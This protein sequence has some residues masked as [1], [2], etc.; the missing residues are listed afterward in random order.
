MAVQGHDKMLH[1]QPALEHVGQLQHQREDRHQHEQ[2]G[3][4][5]AQHRV[6]ERGAILLEP[7]DVAVAARD[8]IVQPAVDERR[9]PGIERI[10]LRMPG[11]AV[12]IEADAVLH[13]LRWRQS[14][15]LRLLQL[16]DA[17]G[18]GVADRLLA[19][20][21]AGDAGGCRRARHFL[22]RFGHVGQS[23]IALFL[24]LGDGCRGADQ[25]VAALAVDLHH[26]RT[27]VG[28]QLGE[29]EGDDGE[30]E[31]Q[32]YR[33]HVAHLAAGEVLGGEEAGLG[34]QR[35]QR[36]QDAGVDV[37][38]AVQQV[39]E[40]VAERTHQSLHRLSAG[41][42]VRAEHRRAAVAAGGLRVRVV[43]AL[44][45]SGRLDVVAAGVHRIAPW[46]V[47]MAAR[48]HPRQRATAH[49]P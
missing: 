21:H 40:Q 47:K 18:G 26:V 24:D 41:V 10:V 17:L 11:F 36:A 27:E 14:L 34:E 33:G 9:R 23:R 45:V 44:R 28:G 29:E 39:A 35:R 49:P 22:L 20:F 25:V 13:R 19:G 32:P 37:E 31:E 1:V 2:R 15:G 30:E 8:L 4:H 5:C 42:A 3:R 7:F 16:P 12:D 48:A 46:A 43:R 38:H 6:L